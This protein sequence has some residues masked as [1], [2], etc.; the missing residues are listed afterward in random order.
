MSKI[1]IIKAIDRVKTWQFCLDIK[2]IMYIIIV[3]SY[4]KFFFSIILAK[5]NM[6]PSTVLLIF[7]SL[8]FRDEPI[9]PARFLEK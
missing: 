1:R 4:V 8:I 6:A 5:A 7:Y 3:P 9:L 2:R